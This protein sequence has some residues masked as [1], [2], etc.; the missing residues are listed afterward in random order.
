M[1]LLRRLLAPLSTLALATPA[2]A[3]P[4]GSTAGSGTTFADVVNSNIVPFFD[5][6]VIPLFYALA[7]LFFLVGLV[8]Y[9]FTGGEENRE[10]GRAFALWGLI[11]MALIFSI[12]GIVKLL[13]SAIPTG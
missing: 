3:Q 9:F 2:L 6:A 8:R 10:K 11:A 4:T 1:I 13:V 7:F 12:W 5:L